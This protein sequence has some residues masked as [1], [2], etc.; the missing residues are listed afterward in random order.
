LSE[1]ISVACKHSQFTCVCER[2]YNHHVLCFLFLTSLLLYHDHRDTAD[3]AT[4]LRHGYFTMYPDFASTKDVLP[5]IIKKATAALKV[6]PVESLNVLHIGFAT[7]SSND[8]S[9][10]HSNSTVTSHYTLHHLK[11]LGQFSCKQQLS[12]LSDH[13]PKP[14]KSPFPSSTRP[15]GREQCSCPDSACCLSVRIEENESQSG[16]FLTR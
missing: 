9:T 6:G 8:V 12:I 4:L 2:I 3:V 10:V 11:L 14:I 15:S 7:H 1:D 13:H 16:Q 5:T